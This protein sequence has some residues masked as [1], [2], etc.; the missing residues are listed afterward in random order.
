MYVLSCTQSLVSPYTDSNVKAASLILIKYRFWGEIKELRVLK[1]IVP[2]WRQLASRLGFG[3]GEIQNFNMSSFYQTEDATGAMLKEW[4][5][6]D[7]HCSWRKLIQKMR[8]VELNVPAENL[9]RALRNILR[10]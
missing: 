3:D 8:E 9:V 1:D 4:M 10:F 6:R 7:V 2:R 5:R